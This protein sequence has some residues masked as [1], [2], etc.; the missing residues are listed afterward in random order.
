MCAILVNAAIP[1]SRLTQ[2]QPGSVIPI[3]INRSIPLLVEHAVIAH[4]TAGEV[5]DRIA[6][7]ITHMTLPE[8]H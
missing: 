7:E 4:G 8:S 5:D 1:L 3:A 6:L 2:L